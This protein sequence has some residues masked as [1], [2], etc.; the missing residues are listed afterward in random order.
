MYQARF[1]PARRGD[2][3]QTSEAAAA[4]VRA[5]ESDLTR[6]IPQQIISEYRKQGFL[7]ILRAVEGVTRELWEQGLSEY[8]ETGG[9]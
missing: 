1:T 3:F 9:R 2:Y 5:L 8:Y 7:A 4:M 6:F